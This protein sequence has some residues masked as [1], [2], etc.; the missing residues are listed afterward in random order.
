MYI[1]NIVT[2]LYI[3]TIFNITTLYISTML[4]VQCAILLIINGFTFLVGIT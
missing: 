2:T 4:L 3:S 1:Y